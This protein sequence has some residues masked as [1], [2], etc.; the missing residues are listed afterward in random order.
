ME[1]PS[2]LSLQDILARK[3]EGRRERA[4]LSF[5]EKVEIL[6]AMRKRVEPIRRAR[7]ERRK[8]GA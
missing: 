1:R 6:E 4:A 8:T 7:E 2:V 3:A 5:L